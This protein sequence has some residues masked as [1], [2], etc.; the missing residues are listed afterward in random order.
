[1]WSPSLLLS[2]LVLARSGLGAQLAFPVDAP[3][4]HTGKIADSHVDES[5][6]LDIENEG[7]VSSNAETIVS[8][9]SA[10]TKHTTFL[11]LLQRSKSIP[12]LA[13]IGNA[14]VFAPTDQ[15]WQDWADRN[16]PNGLADGGDSGLV[17]GWLGP[18]GL[19]EWMKDEEEVLVERMS[20]SGDA[21][22]ERQALD[23]Q[24]WALRQH[25]LYHILNYTLP[26]SAFL[27]TDTANV[28]LQ[29]T[30]L[31]PMAEEPK[32]PPVPEPGPPWLPRGGEGL[33]G[34]HGQRIRIAAVG[35]DEGGE[36]GKIGVDWQ[37][38]GGA[39]VWDGKEWEKKGNETMKGEKDVKGAKWVRNGVVVGLENVLDMPVSIEETIHTHPS[40]SYLSRVLALSAPPKPLP[41]SFATSPH[42]TVF[43]PSNE[44]FA[45]TFDDIERGYLEGP[46]GDE[47][48]G[49]IVGQM[50]VLGGRKKEVFWSDSL[51]QRE[52][53]IEAVSGRS[54]GISS[55]SRG[56]VTVNTTDAET[57][58]IFASNGVIHIIPTLILPPDFTLLNSAE[59]MLLSLNATRFVS[60][61]RSAN[62]S[63]TYIGEGS[64][65][66]G[67][68]EYTIL[69]PTDDVLDIMDKWGGYGEVTLM[70][71]LAQRS[72]MDTRELEPFKDVSPLAALLQYHI[73]PGKLLPTDLR[74]GQLLATEM[75]TSALGGE[76][77]RLRV[78]MPHENGKSRWETVGEGEVRFGGATVLGKPVKSGNN[79]I[80]L[81][82]SLLSPPDNVL[83]TAVSDLQLSTFVAALY[84]SDLAKSAKHSPATTYFMPHNTAFNDLG[85]TMKY[86]LLPE[87]KDDLR[88]VI[89]YHSV[90][91][92][93]YTQD[94]EVGRT[95]L[96]TLEGGVVVLERAKGKNGTIT[97]GS[98]SKWEGHD[99]GVGAGIPAN[100]ELRPAGVSAWDALTDTGVIHTMDQVAMPADVKITISKLVRGAKQSTMVDLMARAGLGWVLEG[101]EPTREEVQR[102]ELG[103]QVR[104]AD[105]DGEAG[106]PEDDD[107]LS[108]PSYTVLVPS[109]HAFS[110]LNLTHYLSDSSALLSLLKLHI[111]P[112]RPSSLSQSSRSSPLPTRPRAAPTDGQPLSLEDDT[113]Y[114]TL[115]S[116]KSKYGDLAFRQ[117]GD[118]WIVGIRNARGGGFGDSAW[119]TG[120]GRASVRWRKGNG[121]SADFKKKHGND[122]DGGDKDDEDEQDE[123]LWRGGMTLG[124][125]VLVID[126]VLLPYEPSWFSRWGWL[127]LTLSG[128]GVLL[129][130]TAGSIGWWFWT[131]EKEGYEPVLV[132]E[133]EGEGEEQV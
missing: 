46:Y 70:T 42:L 67:G 103:N 35:S 118:G 27:P 1:M 126:S 94:V 4:R 86:L 43:A 28:S 97:L 52:S 124:G 77:Q 47:G 26:P 3:A 74:N 127:T 89:K 45:S 54:L 69:A 40:L 101:R 63:D 50:V 79:M 13:H 99:S 123:R 44:A 85:L 91:G 100:G 106:E 7:E 12:M 114:S 115:L 117:A 24:N 30:L 120:G 32:L 51:S 8:T 10:S 104:A 57:V 23:N 22:A 72:R 73:L 60:L 90:E 61:M 116:G 15:A 5:G 129:L 25:I 16:Q 76:R 59:K 37:G 96:K 131:R 36:S 80:Y 66:K 108:L 64:R 84:A 41:E 113:I 49:R 6:Y 119:V 48:V 58:D 92:V 18:G 112:S 133:D 9:L 78:E 39:V 111:I 75:R 102:V 62:L 122:A 109:D 19:D 93:V 98:P 83:Q 110:R 82:S 38:Q 29:T 55:A 105:A 34:G 21:D 87:G 53:S 14:T 68:E 107:D 56:H 95:S 88:K 33:L 125:G 20:A 2:A 81:I 128:I 71:A 65:E 130:A 11:H 17:A 31:Y 121:N 132:E